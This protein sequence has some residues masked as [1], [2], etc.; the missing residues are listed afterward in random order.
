MK[1]AKPVPFITVN[2]TMYSNIKLEVTLKKMC[3]LISSFNKWHFYLFALFR[4][5]TKYLDY[6]KLVPQ[7][8]MLD[9]MILFKAF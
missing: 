7:F 5:N 2:E 1:P 3:M 4:H 9:I 8:G 6:D